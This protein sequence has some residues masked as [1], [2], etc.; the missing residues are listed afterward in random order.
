M[1]ENAEVCVTIGTGTITV[2]IAND[3][4]VVTNVPSL[5]DGFSM[6]LS[7]PAT[8]IAFGSVVSSGFL[9]CSGGPSGV[10]STT[11]TFVD[12]QTSA[13]LTSPY[14][15]EIFTGASGPPVSTTF[16]T[17]NP[18]A[19]A[20][21]G[22]LHPAGIIGTLASTDPGTPGNEK[23]GDAPHNDYLLG[24]TTFNLTD[25]SRAAL[26]VSAFVF[27]WGTTGTAQDGVPGTPTPGVPEPSSIVLLGSAV[28]GV[29]SLLKRKV[30]GEA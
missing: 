8:G 29:A 16:S 2:T 5:L 18:A 4:T 23:I 25:T 20:G 21:G 6:T 30:Q 24:D 14:D 28:L 7:G 10:C 3:D 9:Q 22:S 12:Q 13:T 26:T 15:W 27:Y 1:Q 11:S 19:L 17:T